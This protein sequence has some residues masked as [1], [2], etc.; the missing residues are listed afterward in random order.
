MRRRVIGV[1]ESLGLAEELGTDALTIEEYRFMER[2][3]KKKGCRCMKNEL[4][5]QD[6][7]RVMVLGKKCQKWK[8]SKR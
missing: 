3:K 6:I 2:A 5:S 7:R 1:I 4:S 8:D